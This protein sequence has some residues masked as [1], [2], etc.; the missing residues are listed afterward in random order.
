[1]KLVCSWTAA[2]IAASIVDSWGTIMLD[3]VCSL[4]SY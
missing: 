1:M 4:H 2:R 3:H